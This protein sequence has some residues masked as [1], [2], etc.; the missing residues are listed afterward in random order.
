MSDES[1][2][3]SDDASVA[4]PDV[5]VI[6]VRGGHGAAERVIRVAHPVGTQ[7]SVAEWSSVEGDVPVREMSARALYDELDEALRHRRLVS[8]ELYQVRRWL[9]LP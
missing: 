3:R 6:Q 8:P 1:S 4:V 5:L 7:V 9:G 2:A